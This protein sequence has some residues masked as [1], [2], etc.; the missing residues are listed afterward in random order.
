MTV[1]CV[2][3]QNATYVPSRIIRYQLARLF[4]LVRFFLDCLVVWVG[5]FLCVCAWRGGGGGGTWPGADPCGPSWLEL[6]LACL[7]P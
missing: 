1:W 7:A 3:S 6:L 5:A 4:C 2:I